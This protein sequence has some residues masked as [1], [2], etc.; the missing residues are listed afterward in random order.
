V[1]VYRYGR[2]WAYAMWIDGELDHS[3]KLKAKTQLMALGEVLD[4]FPNAR[5]VVLPSSEVQP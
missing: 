5:L 3:G 4:M 2:K 1:N